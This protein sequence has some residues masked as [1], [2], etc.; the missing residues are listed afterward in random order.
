MCVDSDSKIEWCGLCHN[1]RLLGM[2]ETIGAKLD[3]LATLGR[4]LIHKVT[5]LKTRFRG[6]IQAG[7]EFGQIGA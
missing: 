2:S 7:Q 3:C 4:G 1:R 5:Q 6:H